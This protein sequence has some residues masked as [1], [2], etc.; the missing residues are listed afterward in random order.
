MLTRSVLRANLTKSSFMELVRELRFRTEAPI[1]DC[2]EALREANNDLQNA[3]ELLRKKGLARA[4]KKG[5]RVTEYGTVVACVGGE[6]GGAVITVCSETDFA[7]RSTQF[8][9]VCASVMETFNQQIICSKG[10]ILTDG[11]E[12]CRALTESVGDKLRASIA[13]LGENVTIKSVQPFRVASHKLGGVSIG[14]YTHGE[15][16]VPNVGRVAGLVALSPAEAGADVPR[17]LLVGVARHFVA[18]SGAEG[19]FASQTFFG[20]DETVGEW[21]RRNALR[22]ISSLVVDFGKE[23][24]VHTAPEQFLEGSK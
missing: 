9:H 18:C 6:F 20:A 23:P 8:H 17:P 7:A 10:E 15:L 14:S 24:V 2:S 19:D 3:V 5:S 16:G 4:A 12:A 13:V 11:S 1:A 22:F 21:L